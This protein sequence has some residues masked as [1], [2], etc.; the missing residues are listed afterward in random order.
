MQQTGDCTG[1]GLDVRTVRWC[2]RREEW[3]H[4]GGRSFVSWDD[5]AG[6]LKGAEPTA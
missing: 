4:T 1:A 3:D 5:V 2:L 6:F